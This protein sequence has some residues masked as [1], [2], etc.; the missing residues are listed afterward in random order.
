[1]IT[2]KM[3]LKRKLIVTIQG[4]NMDDYAETMANLPIKTRKL[5]EAFNDKN[6]S[7]AFDIADDI[8]NDC[9]ALKLFILAKETIHEPA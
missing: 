1:M 3:L 7:A 9:F 5:H 8:Q 6:M 2:G 4:N